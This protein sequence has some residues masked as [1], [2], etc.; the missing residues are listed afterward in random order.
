[1]R[2]ASTEYDQDLRHRLGKRVRSPHGIVITETLAT[3]QALRAAIPDHQFD[4]D[5]AKADVTSWAVR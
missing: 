2:A 5:Q 4:Y 1:V 3:A